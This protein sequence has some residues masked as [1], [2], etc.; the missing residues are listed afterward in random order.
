MPAPFVP[1]I[2]IET[3]TKSAGHSTY[4]E[5]YQYGQ[6]GMVL[7]AASASG[8]AQVDY[9]YLDGRPVAT[10][11]PSTGALNFLHDDMLG[12]PQLATDG[13]QTVAWQATYEPFGQAS[14]SGTI[15]QNL[16]FPWAV[17][18]CRKRLEPQ[19]VPKLP[20]RSGALHGARSAGNAGK[21]QIL[22]P[23]HRQLPIRRPDWLCRRVQLLSV[24]F[25]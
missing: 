18:R 10:L 6:N 12:T 15:T 17:L 16:R 25:R 7:E 3:G 22:Q 9:I 2:L 13:S 24:R 5:I 8:V 19:R 14:V 11:N 1:V 21:R 23:K 20:A 4:G